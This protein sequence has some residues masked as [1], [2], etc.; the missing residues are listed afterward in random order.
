MATDS[1]HVEQRNFVAWFRQAHRGV[2]IFAIPNGGQRSLSVAG[3]LKAEGVVAGVP[4]LY[5]PEWRLWV[6]MK[7]VKGG[8]LSAAQADW[9]DHLTTVCGDAVIVAAGCEDAK[10][11]V[12]DHLLRR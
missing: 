2:R 5:V 6:E 12:A 10:A 8:R 9:I 11:Q 7:R 3:R 1:E 4:D